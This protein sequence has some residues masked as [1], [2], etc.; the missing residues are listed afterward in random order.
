MLLSIVLM[1]RLVSLVCRDASRLLVWSQIHGVLCFSFG[2]IGGCPPQQPSP[3][4]DV[5]GF[6]AYIQPRH[7]LRFTTAEADNDEDQ[8]QASPAGP[9]DVCLWSISEQ[10]QPGWASWRLHPETWRSL[11]LND[12]GRNWRK[13]LQLNRWICTSYTCKYVFGWRVTWI[14][15]VTIVTIIVMWHSLAV[16][17]SWKRVTDIT[18]PGLRWL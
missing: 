3:H 11:L 17:S 1:R 5:R 13:E 2:G 16:R 4:G 15:N 10:R 18:M 14:E 8:P 6:A 7:L 12:R 9:D